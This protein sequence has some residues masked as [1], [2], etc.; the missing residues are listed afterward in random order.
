MRAAIAA[1]SRAEA[2][3]SA[4]HRAIQ[5]VTANVSGARDANTQLNQ[6]LSHVRE[7]LGASNE[8][9]LALKN[10]VEFLERE[11][12]D[13]REQVEQER[14][15]L[16][17]DQDR[18]LAGLLE[19][20]EQALARVVHDREALRAQLEQLARR[21]AA[22]ERRSSV[23][24]LERPA[25]GDS[26]ELAEARRIIEKLG[27]ERDR[28]RELLRR[29]QA[30][31]DD[32][33]AQLASLLR[34]N[35]ELSAELT[36]LRATAPPDAVDGKR[37]MP[38]RANTPALGEAE[39][40]GDRPTPVAQSQLSAETRHGASWKRPSSPLGARPPRASSAPPPAPS[41]EPSSRRRCSRFRASPIQY[42]DRSGGTP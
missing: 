23:T 32:A 3:L 26:H 21:D 42:P 31:R 9:R 35:A 28:S 24:P 16:I 19:E 40:D 15:F 33:Q 22:E 25:A 39:L 5:Q 6:E 2:S 11:L 13:A 34:E 30:Q 8:E 41:L 38:A 10:Q 4:L 36:R 29:L 1:S 14:R 20:H 27:N 12:S 7:V 17:E 18:F 37:T